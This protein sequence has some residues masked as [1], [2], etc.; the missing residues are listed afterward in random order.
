MS[1]DYT[2]F[3][4]DRRDR[5]SGVLMQQGRV[6][7]DSDW[8]EEI[9]IERNRTRVLTLDSFGPFGIPQLT[10]PN[11]FTLG[12]IA[13]PPADLSIVPGRIYVGGILAE[14][15][16][17]ENATYLNQ[18][19]L[20]T[21]PA[22]P[23]GDSVV[24]L[25]VWDRE[26]TYIE[27]PGLLDPALGGADTATRN[28]T[29]WQL[30]VTARPNATC[31]MPV[32]EAPSAGQ[33]TTQ[34]NAPPAPDDPCILPPIAGYRGLENRLYRVEVHVPGPLGTAR[35]KWSRDNGSIVSAV[36]AIGVSGGQTT[37]TVNR[38]GR[39]KVLR[40]RV[41]DWVTVTDDHRELMAEAGEMALIV[42][43]DEAARQIVLDRALPTGANRAF[44]ANAA[45]IAA[46]HTRVQRWDQTAASNAI[47]A[48]GLIATSVLVD[49]ED[50]V[51]VQ[52]GTSPAT[53]SFRIGDYWVFA[54]R[55]ANA[56]VEPL[57][58]APPRG[59]EH[60]YVQLAAITGLAG[61][62]N[63]R[64]DNCR[65]PEEECC[66]TLVVAP[67]ENI[68][69]AINKLPPQGGCVCLKTGIHL[70]DQPVVIGRSNVALK[71]ESRGTIVRGVDT[72]TVLLIGS[73][74]TLVR[75]VR[76]ESIDFEVVDASFR[77]TGSGAIVVIA[78]ATDIAIDDCRVRTQGFSSVTGIG[79]VRS[80]HV[81]ISH[82]TV[83]G[84][85]GGIWAISAGRQLDL[86]ANELDFATRQD[87]NPALFGILIQNGSSP[88][89]VE[90]N[91]VNGAL[92]G[93]V[94]NDVLFGNAAPSSFARGSV[95]AGN[96]I[97]GLQFQGQTGAALQLV[98]IDVAADY[99]SITGNK[100]S[101]QHTFYIGIRAT[102]SDT[103]VTGNTLISELKETNGTGPIGIALGF[104]ADG[105]DAAI[106]RV[107]AAH[108]VLTGPQYGIAAVGVTRLIV[109]A[110]TI[111]TSAGLV[112]FGIYLLRCREAAIA[113]NRIARARVGILCTSGRLNRLSGN[114]IVDGDLGI[115]IGAETGPAV[116]G[117]RLDR[118]SQSGVLAVLI[119]GRVD[120]VGNRLVNCAYGQNP[121]IGLGIV[122]V[123]GEAHI[124]ANEVM[125]V[126]L[127]PGGAATN[128]AF[129]I[130][131][132]LVL[133]CR[134]ESNLVTF[135]N[136]F[137]RDPNRE[138]RALRIRGLL[139][140]Q[141]N[142][143]FVLGAAIQVIDNQFVGTGR[144]A[145]VEIFRTQVT[146]N[147]FVGFD[148]VTFNQNVCTH[149]SPVANDARA[150]V[151]LAARQAIVIGNHIKATTPKYNSVDF[152]ATP[153]PYIGNVTT[154]E[155][156][157]HIDFPVPRS[158]FN[159]IA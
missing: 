50:G 104:A 41:G 19:F 66:C 103:Q 8:N 76:V 56:W 82:T 123:L 90:R 60:H 53:G 1:G 26:V 155:T 152:N 70:V 100:V 159:M 141:I 59:I 9:D 37:L 13:G 49:I 30:K 47:D 2:R 81:T 128:P 4:F 64:I 77:P 75:G 119:F 88:C 58:N 45:Q 150:T 12:L 78:L 35:F 62:R 25:D 67:G 135:S 146:G 22:L 158:A 48:N 84:T 87:S 109:E 98:G 148:R 10:T 61:G 33:L 6:Q 142:D 143:G 3:T 145:L 149:L 131:G 94:L 117:N 89:R 11:A 112:V 96:F 137:S 156:L 127:A 20:P 80:D 115:G 147:L 46:R 36:T 14:L 108:N 140:L 111:D 91:T 38:I 71:G 144:T 17:G 24:Y 120:I 125:D 15:F 55:T 134:V 21:P 68:N 74:S 65:P 34:A 105:L 57:N 122:F 54:A 31:D 138:D 85:R 42:N 63:P 130:I 28:Q 18:P 118:L 5:Y 83:S 51:Q 107:I 97:R 154:G 113:D 132:D 16:P 106:A 40:F 43:I 39:D 136:L 27:D 116:T 73:G 23:A 101:Y 153:G 99:C 72:G 79:I 124:E 29:V 7:L 86:F 92:F 110:N 69:A 139:D 93:I 114:A 44:G 126:G 157:Q 32:G 151:S 129:G 95:I 133:E 52:F 121:A 102:G